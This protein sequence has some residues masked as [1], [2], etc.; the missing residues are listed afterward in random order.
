V[1]ELREQHRLRLMAIAI[2][3]ALVLADIAEARRELTAGAA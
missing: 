1:L 2:N 3:T